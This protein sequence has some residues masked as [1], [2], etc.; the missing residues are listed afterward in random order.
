MKS[1]VIVFVSFAIIST[2]SMTENQREIL[3]AAHAECSAE[4][5]VDEAKV[6]MALTGEAAVDQSVKDH[7]FCIN[8][9]I[10]VQNDAGELQVDAIRAE[11]ETAVA[12]KSIIDGMMS[13][14][15]VQK[16]TPQDTAFE[17]NKCFYNMEHKP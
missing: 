15:V 12:D 9:K 11:V 3:M 13:T 17:T 16:S 8:K 10:G 7:M 4:T 14:C 1:I 6:R 2:Q 5:G